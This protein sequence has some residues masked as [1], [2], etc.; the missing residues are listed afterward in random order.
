MRLYH[1][2]LNSEEIIKKNQIKPNTS[3]NYINY[4]NHIL[5]NSSIL[6]AG[7]LMGKYPGSRTQAPFMG[8]GVY[9]FNDVEKAKIYQSNA[10]VV[11]I[12]CEPTDIYDFDDPEWLFGTF[13]Y[14]NNEVTEKITN[15]YKENESMKFGW[16]TLV[17]FLIRCIQQNFKKNEPA[18]GIVIFILNEF[19]RKERPDLIINT[20]YDTIEL[21]KGNEIE[22]KYFLIKNTNKITGLSSYERGE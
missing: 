11:I 22:V 21:S 6:K 15:L 4:V 12:D 17:E 14:L 20:F 3:F 1:S 10:E 18:L 13:N 16:L 2:T 19:M 9:C 7:E 5:D 8:N